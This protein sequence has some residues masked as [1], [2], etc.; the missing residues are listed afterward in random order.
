MPDNKA[1]RHLMT[2]TVVSR[3][4]SAM[5]PKVKLPCLHCGTDHTGAH[6]PACVSGYTF[7]AAEIA[8]ALVDLGQGGSYCQVSALLRRNAMRKRRDGRRKPMTAP[9]TLEPRKPLPP[10]TPRNLLDKKAAAKPRPDGPLLRKNYGYTAPKATETAYIVPS[11]SGNLAQGYVDVF[12]PVIFDAFPVKEWPSIVIIDSLPIKRRRIAVSKRSGKITKI[13]SG[14]SQGE[15]FAAADGSTTPGTPI[16]A[17]LEGSK[18]AT[19]VKRFLDRLP[20]NTEPV[21]VVADIDE[22]IR[23]AVKDKWP[24]ANFY[25]CEEHLKMRCRLALE[26]DGIGPW[27]PFDHADAMPR[28]TKGVK[29]TGYGIEHRLYFALHSAMWTEKRWADFAALVDRIVKPDKVKTRNWV[30]D[31]TDL[32]HSQI[33]LRATHKGFPRSTGAIEGTI[34]RIKHVVS[35]RA[36]Y[37]RN[38]VRL[39]KL[40]NLVRLDAT[41][42]ADADVYASLITKHLLAR[43]GAGLD[44]QSGRD[45]FG[46]GSID[47]RIKQAKDEH[48]VVVFERDKRAKQ[49]RLEAQTI[50]TNAWLAERGLPPIS[51]A[52]QA[53]AKDPIYQIPRWGRTIADYPALVMQYDPSRNEGLL[54]EQVTAASPV[55]RTWV[56][57]AHR[58]A[59]GGHDHV[60]DAPPERRTNG[61]GCPVCAGREVCEMNSL[62]YCRPDLTL[63]WYQ[64]KNGALTPDNVTPNRADEVFWKCLKNKKHKPFRQRIYNRHALH[65]GCPACFEDEQKER[66]KANRNEYAQARRGRASDQRPPTSLPVLDAAARKAKLVVDPT[67]LT[68]RAAAAAVGCSEQTIRNWIHEGRI[69]AHTP[70]IKGKPFLVPESEVLRVRAILEAPVGPDQEAA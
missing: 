13:A 43:G 12:A 70:A 55:L 47:A 39:D 8:G 10:R 38:G 4:L 59:T 49:A 56:C 24:N 11:R 3:Q 27:V 16:L 19:S 69:R 66:A 26:A 15:I 48:A 60:W 68:P 35:E 21:W 28:D 6:G 45:L 23:V 51:K 36:E 25:R 52:R 9:R 34:R 65:E 29:V 17:G 14:E 42:Q 63:E 54:P 1:D 62:R 58:T 53:D 67:D 37:Y 50:A 61:S 57:S 40:V 2:P 41:G 7:A 64:P 32:V 31:N 22:G 44:W 30:A 20:T 18:D 46:S 5:H 33:S